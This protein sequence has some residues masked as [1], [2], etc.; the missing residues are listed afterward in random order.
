[1]RAST[2]GWL[3]IVLVFI[4]LPGDSLAQLKSLET[5]RLKLIYID[6][7]Q[8]YLTPHAA[9]CFES[10]MDFQ[11]SFF[12]FEPSEPVTVILR[13]TA[14]FGGGS[15]GVTPRNNLSVEIAPLSF[16]FETMPPGEARSCR[17]PTIPRRSATST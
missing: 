11:T 1:M 15:A 12:D 8:T 6:P 2:A 4:C 5:E 10:S 16:A 17:R 13:D 7:T 9:R 14:D 3:A